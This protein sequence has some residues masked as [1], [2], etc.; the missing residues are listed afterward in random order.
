MSNKP[1][2]A[3]LIWLATGDPRILHTA[4]A[5]VRVA[6]ANNNAGASKIICTAAGAKNIFMA[7]ATLVKEAEDCDMFDARVA[8][9]FH[10]SRA[11]WT[12]PYEDAFVEVLNPPDAIGVLLPYA[13]RK[14]AV[15]AE[16]IPQAVLYNAEPEEEEKVESSKDIF[17]KPFNSY[18][19]MCLRAGKTHVEIAQAIGVR[20]ST[21]NS[22]KS[23]GRTPKAH[24]TGAI[25]NTIKNYA[26]SL[27]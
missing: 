21:Y 5:L 9:A 17:C 11:G 14:E 16:G 4:E 10:M 18:I 23:G 8:T 15:L 13:P 1:I 2:L 26:E 12:N 25:L 20:Y 7:V 3:R 22:W 19:N 27:E 24:D 6:V